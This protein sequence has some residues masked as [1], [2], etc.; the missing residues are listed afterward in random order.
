MSEASF[1]TNGSQFNLRRLEKVLF[2]VVIANYDASRIW[3]VLARDE[4]DAI[5]RVQA[6][7]DSALLSAQ[8]EEILFDSNGVLSLL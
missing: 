5:E 6:T 8:A 7:E 3:L 2:K 4:A 1:K